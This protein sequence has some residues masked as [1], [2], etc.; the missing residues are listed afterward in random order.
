MRRLHEDFIERWVSFMKEN[1]DKWKKNHTEF[2][3][4]QFEK[5]NQIIEKLSKTK[6]GKQ[7]IIKMYKIKN[8]EGYKELL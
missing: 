4:A 1:P 3:D 2:I 7:K 8:K 6:E 5:A